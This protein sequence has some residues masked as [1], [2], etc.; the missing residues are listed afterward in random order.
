[1]TTRPWVILSKTTASGSIVMPSKP[2]DPYQR[3]RQ[4]R[5]FFNEHADME[6]Y[7]RGFTSRDI[8]LMDKYCP[9]AATEEDEE[10]FPA[11][12]AKNGSSM[13]SSRSYWRKKMEDLDE[14]GEIAEGDYNDDEVKIQIARNGDEDETAEA[15]AGETEQPVG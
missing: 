2:I 7:P 5:R 3:G 14:T 1:M 6:D 4:L 8:E 9:Q 13:A 12:W 10:S 11:I 15:R